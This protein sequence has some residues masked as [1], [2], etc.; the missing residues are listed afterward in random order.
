MTKPPPPAQILGTKEGFSLPGKKQYEYG[1]NFLNITLVR[2][3][4][5]DKK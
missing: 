1:L 3:G 5:N 2:V 4:R